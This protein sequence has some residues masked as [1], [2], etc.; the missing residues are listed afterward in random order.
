MCDDVKLVC[1]ARLLGRAARSAFVCN[2]RND[3][4]IK[5]EHVQST[6]ANDEYLLV[7]LCAMVS[8]G[9]AKGKA[10]RP[11]MADG[12]RHT[13]IHLH[14]KQKL[15]KA[16]IARQ[17][18]RS[19]PAVSKLIALWEK[20]HDWRPYAP[21]GR[22]RKTTPKQDKKLLNKVKQSPRKSRAELRTW[23]LSKTGKKVSKRTIGRRLAEAGVRSASTRPVPK[24]TEGHR[25][26]R[27]KWARE[28]RNWKI[29]DWGRFLFSDESRFSI[30]GSNEHRVRVW[31]TPGDP[32]DEDFH[33][34]A[35]KYKRTI[36]VLGFISYHGPGPL[37]RCDS[38]V[39]SKVYIALL[40]GHLKPWIRDLEEEDGTPYTF[41]Q[42]GAFCHTSNE[43]ITWIRSAGI[44]LGSHP[45]CSP[46]L[47]PIEH[48]WA[49]MARQLSTMD[50][51]NDDELYEAL[52]DSWL[53]IPKSFFLNLYGSM[54]SR[55]NEVIANRGGN[56]SY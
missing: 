41:V 23:L 16:E 5:E 37:V 36:M 51:K 38:R 22:P 17:V 20:T 27:L 52:V 56:T 34:K 6:L 35:R 25:R 40:K 13:I 28:R 31:K 48:C 12:E 24:L 18:G 7:N 50:I 45:P 2:S 44:R 39:N 55:V 26:Q 33:H 14:H 42:D 11:R 1:D 53:S 29:G 8:E 4:G 21:P 49:Y 3:W 54:G 10:V 19:R 43:T 47:N 46:D 32:N 30:S 15:I 9:M